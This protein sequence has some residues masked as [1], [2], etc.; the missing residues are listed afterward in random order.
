M[1]L[2]RSQRRPAGSPFTVADHDRI[3]VFYMFIVLFHFIEHILQ[4]IQFFFLGYTRS[5]AGG[6]LGEQ[7][8]DL[9]TNETLHF[10]YNLLLLLGIIVLFRGF[11]GNA[12]LWWMVAGMLQGWHFFEHAILQ[13]QYVTGN[14]WFGAD[15]QTSVLEN[16]IPRI[17]LH[18]MYNT[19]VTF[20]ILV[21][22]GL[23]LYQ[24]HQES[25][26]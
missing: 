18:F 16:F 23:H 7:F 9:L 5:M 22:V 2:T 6:L 10:G 19:V 1:Q 20:A 4:I 26:R 3:L 24:R 17:E 14:Y 25:R 13:W 15:R 21:A 8:P 12:Q 11:K